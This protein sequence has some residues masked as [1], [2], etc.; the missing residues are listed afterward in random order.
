MKRLFF[1]LVNFVLIS[2]CAALL[3]FEEILISEDAYDL[4]KIL[5]EKDVY[6]I[7]YIKDIQ[8]PETA[9]SDSHFAKLRTLG[10][11]EC[12]ATKKGWEN[13]IDSSQEK[14][15][16]RRV[17]QN[18]SYWKNQDSLLTISMMYFNNITIK[19]DLNIKIPSN[20]RQHVII[21]YTNDPIAKEQLGINCQP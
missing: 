2:P 19:D 16:K 9:L 13:F 3:P 5:L 15:N 1:V 21:I 6:Q 12:F 7:S 11:S 10:W 17:F 4:K 8:Y 14:D 18:I 20:K